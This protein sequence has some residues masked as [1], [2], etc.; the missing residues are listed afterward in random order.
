VIGVTRRL[1]CRDLGIDFHY[2]KFSD[3]GG[4]ATLDEFILAE[5]EASRHGRRLTEPQRILNAARICKTVFIPLARKNM[6]D[7]VRLPES[8]R[9]RAHER[10]AQVEGVPGNAIKTALKV[11]DTPLFDLVAAGEVRLSLAAKYPDLEADQQA[12]INDAIQRSDIQEAVGILRGDTVKRDRK[13]KELPEQLIPLFDCRPFKKHAKALRKAAEW[14][15]DTR[16]THPTISDF[17]WEGTLFDFA[18]RLLDAEPFAICPYC[19]HQPSPKRSECPQCK[20]GRVLTEKQF[21]NWQ[22]DR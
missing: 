13:K 9:F 17:A 10:A 21:N 7:G 18:T 2:E 3:L 5:Y 12:D 8:D 11:L 4:N 16:A 1:G 19:E 20:G 6:T 22:R 14:L 15:R